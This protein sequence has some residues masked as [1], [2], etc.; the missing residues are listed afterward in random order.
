LPP[1]Q[2]TARLLGYAGIALIATGVTLV[3]VDAAT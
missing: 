2:R 3:V 1:S